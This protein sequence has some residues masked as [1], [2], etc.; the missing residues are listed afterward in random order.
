[1]DHQACRRGVQKLRVTFADRAF[2]RISQE[3]VEVSGELRAMQLKVAGQPVLFVNGR[4]VS[5][6]ITNSVLSYQDTSKPRL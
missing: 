3:R 2:I 1:M 6:T 4:V 5:A